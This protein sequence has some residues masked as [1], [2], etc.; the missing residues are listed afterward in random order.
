MATYFP[1]A[2]QNYE[3]LSSLMGLMREA[4][5]TGQW[6]RLLT[7][8]QQAQERVRVMRQADPQTTLDESAKER[9]KA[10]ILKMLADDAT[11]RH[12][13]QPWMEKLQW[14]LRSSRQE[15]KVR[16]AYTPAR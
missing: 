4:A 2:V 7:L 8:E 1:A 3:A 6:D 16:R 11:I 15:Q 13:T 14:A 5:S 9:K 12:H 10:L